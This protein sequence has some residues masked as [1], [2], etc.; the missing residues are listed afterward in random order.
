MQNKITEPMRLLDKNGHVTSP[1]YATSLIWEYSRKDIKAPKFRIKEWDYY[2][3]LNNDY[4]VA[5]T[6]ADN[7][8]L[9][10]VSASVMEWKSCKNITTAVM[11]PFPLGKFH[12]PPSSETGD[13]MF[14]NKRAYVGF[15]H[16]GDDRLLEID[17]D[18]FEGDQRLSGQITLHQD[19][20]ADTMVIATP[21]AEN[22][23]TFYYNQKINCMRAEGEIKLGDK[24]YTFAP[25]DSFG[26]LDWGRGVWTYSNTWYWGSGSGLIGDN[27]FGFNI[28]YGF[29]DRSSASENMLFFNGRAHKLDQVEFHIPED[30]YLK[31]WR[32]TSNDNRFEMDFVPILDRFDDTN[33]G[34]IRSCQHQVFGRFSGVAVL[35]DG[36]KVEVKDFLGFA[37]KVANRW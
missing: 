19:K 15:S 23:K 22:P 33:V 10:F 32:F 34:I 2:I 29:S 9:G 16:K 35:D 37:E 8:Y 20:S 24:I 4:A 36:T 11:T 12:M 31:P 6:V 13:I 1:G 5:M 3:A 7:G 14:A 21:F 30:S 18:N 17:F 25:H 26:T 28:G 27:L